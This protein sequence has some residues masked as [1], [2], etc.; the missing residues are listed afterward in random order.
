MYIQKSQYPEL[1]QKIVKMVT[2]KFKKKLNDFFTPKEFNLFIL[3]YVSLYPLHFLT[4][5]L[6]KTWEHKIS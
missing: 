4:T 2:Q 1:P 5:N 6:Q 3:K